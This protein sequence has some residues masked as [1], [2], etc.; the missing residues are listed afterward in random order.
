[1]TL[2]LGNSPALARAVAASCGSEVRIMDEAN[3]RGRSGECLF[4]SGMA[5]EASVAGGEGLDMLAG[6]VY[7]RVVFC[8]R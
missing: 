5:F 7:S 2:G 6:C 4:E 8:E 1:V 3:V